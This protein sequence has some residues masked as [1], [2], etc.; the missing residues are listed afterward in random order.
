MQVGT[1][2][3]ESWLAGV[4]A[5]FLACAVLMANNLRDLEQDALA[6]KRTLAVLVGSLPARIL[7]AVFMTIPFVILVF[8]VL[9]YENA[10]LVY[11]TL[12][13]AAPTILIG[14]TGKTP[15]RVPA[16]AEARQPHRVG[17]RV[18]TRRGH[19]VLA[20]AGAQRPQSQRRYL[21]TP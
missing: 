21:N 16:R 2:T 19:R 14:V 1:V 7:F 6:H 18:G 3:I 4:A 9:F 13:L 20:A 17:L 11:F 15:R 8:F 10:A 5:G 12:L